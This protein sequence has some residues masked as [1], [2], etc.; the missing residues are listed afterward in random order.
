MKYS[1]AKARRAFDR[2]WAEMKLG[3]DYN[4]PY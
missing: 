1:H 2:K 3:N 4:I